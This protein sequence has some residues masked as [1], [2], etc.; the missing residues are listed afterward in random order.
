VLAIL[1]DEEP[2]MA[3][4]VPRWR[5]PSPVIA[6]ESGQSSI[7][8]RQRLNRQAGVYW[9]ARSSRAM[10]VEGMAPTV[11]QSETVH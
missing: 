11:H 1:V 10:T 8:K 9:I 3:R 5:G 6:R 7:R 2:A 4:I